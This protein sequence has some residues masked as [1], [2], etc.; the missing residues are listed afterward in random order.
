MNKWLIASALLF[1][2][3][4]TAAQSDV[5]NCPEAVAS[6][7]DLITQADIAL[8]EERY[9]DSEVLLHDARQLIKTTCGNTDSAVGDDVTI[10]S[11]DAQI[12]FPEL[13]PTD[14][15]AYIRVI[16]T[17][18]DVETPL[19]LE[20][21]GF[22]DLVTGLAFGESTGLIAIPAGVQRLNE[23]SWDFLANS[24]WVVANVGLDENISVQI[25]P[26]SILRND[27]RGKARIRIMQA[28]SGAERFNITSKE[29]IDFGT[30]LGWLNFHDADIM[31]GQ[32]TLYADVGGNGVIIPE[33]D[34]TFE[35][36]HNYT[37]FLIGG[38]DGAPAPHFLTLVSPQDVTRVRFTNDR[39]EAVDIHQRPG[40]NQ[41]VA[42]LDSGDTSDWVII[43]SGAVAFIAYD[44]GTG[45][46]GQEKASVSEHLRT[47]RD[48]T[49]SIRPNGNI[50]LED[51]E[52]TP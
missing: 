19:D 44:V 26:V 38:K 30:G 51:V 23:L 42:A 13:N 17:V 37:I 45:P 9:A 12:T 32:Y 21:A 28:I 3:L 29:G 10:N 52:F 39:A 24:T 49:F 35:A 7:R 43:P 5:K 50:R 31:P 2:V 8:T 18:A 22:G 36:D 48:L 6:A 34:F 40:N 11:G 46:G 4:P 33:T 20:L 27:L 14:S 16:N 15:V 41:I 25:E 47:G 1:L